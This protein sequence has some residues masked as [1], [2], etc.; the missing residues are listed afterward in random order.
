M[1]EPRQL[2]RDLGLPGFLTFQLAVGGSALAA[3]VHP[4]FVASLIYFGAIKPIWL[5]GFTV[6][7]GYLASA[8]LGWLGLKRRGLLA[9]AWILLL[10]PV[11]WLLL[12]LAAWRALYQL[13]VAPYAWEKTEHGLAKNSRLAEN[14]T[15]ALLELEHYFRTQKE[16]GNLPKLEAETRNTSASPR[17]LPRAA[18]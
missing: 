10:T 8:F 15:R 7:A 18:A 9:G 14:L 2:L 12:S 11:H 4:L 6:T 16:S 3:L 17:P 5:Y 1:R 13:V